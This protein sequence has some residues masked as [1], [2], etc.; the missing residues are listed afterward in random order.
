MSDDMINEMD[1]DINNME[2]KPSFGSRLGRAFVRILRGLLVLIII[3]G[4]GAAVYYGVPYFY[5]KIILPIENNTAQLVEVESQRATD[6]EQLNSQIADLQS[7][8][9]TLETRQTK[10]AQDITELTGQVSVLETAV[11]THTGSLKQLEAMQKSLE[12]LTGSVEGHTT[13]LTGEDSVLSDLRRE[14][15]ISRSIELLSRTRLYLSQSNFGMARQD[16]VAARD[17]LLSIKEE[18]P[19]DKAVTMETVL[20]Q[21]DLAL[22]NLPAFPVIAVNDVDIAWQLLVTNLPDRI[23][24]A[25]ETEVVTTATPTITVEETPTANP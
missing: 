11:A 21:L 6:M 14:I 20:A 1:M 4:L 22:E 10:N 13:L 25:P 18:I 24:K 8:L 2:P 9:T 5:Q 17:L 19:A 16:V 12:A 3:A 15:I 23:Q 7:R